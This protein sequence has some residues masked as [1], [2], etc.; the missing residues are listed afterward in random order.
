MSARFDAD[1]IKVEGLDKMLKALRQ[2]PPI[3]RIGIL[4]DKTTR[5]AKPGEKRVPT[6]AEIGAAHEYGSPSKGLPQRSFLRVPIGDRL[7]KEMEKAGA[8]SKAEF[9]EVMKQGSVVPWLKKI[10]ALAEGIVRGAFDSKGYGLWP[11]WKDPNYTNNANQ[12]LVDT[13]QLRDSITSE[14]KES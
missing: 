8:L 14:V 3:A 10:A 1:T 2:K 5:K 13:T 12:V 4:G 9:R 11:S 7:Q 6:N